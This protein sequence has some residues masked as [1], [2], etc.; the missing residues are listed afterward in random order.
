MP[1]NQPRSRALRLIVA[2]VAAFIVT[3]LATVPASVITVVLPPT[4]KLGITS[5]TLWSGS[6]DSL[7]VNGRPYGALRWKLRPLQSFLGRLVI[8]G[9]LLRNDGQARGKIGLGLG[10]RL[11]ARNMEINLPLAA[12]ASGVGPPG[13]SGVVRAKLQSV[14]LAPQTA[15][16][17][18]G[19]I[20]VHG[21]QAPPPGGA[22]I[23]SYAITFDASSARDGKLIGQLKDLEGPMQ[24]TGTATLAADRS[25]VVEGMVAP[26]A[27]APR[28]VT[29]TLRFLG[30]PDAQ[31]RRPFSVAGTY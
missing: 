18:V 1:D 8:D 28:A 20:E 7:T 4:I 23:G 12:L 30:A 14:D 5:G 24:V 15:P 19:A 25:Y 3:L 29:D 2:G 6:T 17:I 22:A 27:G 16:R 10:H 21:L 31:G 13:W 26:R 11:F 9:E